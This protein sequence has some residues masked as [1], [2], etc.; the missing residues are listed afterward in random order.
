MQRKA[1]GGAPHFTCTRQGQRGAVVGPV[2]QH[3]LL[4][5]MNLV[6][7]NLQD[8]VVLLEE[9]RSTKAG[10]GEV[11][12]GA[13][14]LLHERQQPKDLGATSGSTS[15]VAAAPRT[16]PCFEERCQMR[17]SYLKLLEEQLGIAEN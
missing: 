8:E 12:S 11:P 1:V 7:M 9:P 13:V 3:L 5:V 16:F 17:A 6:A 2:G 4:A 15:K 10:W 14:G